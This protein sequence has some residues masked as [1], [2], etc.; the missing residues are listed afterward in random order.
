MRSRLSGRALSAAPGTQLRVLQELLDAP[1]MGAGEL[2]QQLA[3]HQAT[4]SNLVEALAKK[5]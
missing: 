3:I 1:G 2:A 5:T 4:A